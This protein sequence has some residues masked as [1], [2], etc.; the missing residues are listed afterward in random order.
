MKE[1]TTGSIEN[2][3]NYL[4]A[5]LLA[6]MGIFVF[7]NVFLRY[8]FNSGLIWAEELSRYLFVWLVFLGAIGA[9][10]DNN[11]LGFTSLVQKLPKKLKTVCFL[12]SNGLILG[13]LIVLL[14]GSASMTMMTVDT[15]SPVLEIPMAAMY[16]VGII[17]SASM[18]VIVCYRVYQALFVGGAIDELVVLKESEEEL[19]LQTEGK[20]G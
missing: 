6:L 15:L 17:T 10:K 3:F 1:N 8:F 2:L 4:M 16:G 18:I 19:N 12:V 5:I 13:C 20:E 11:H 7:T 14:D 9:L